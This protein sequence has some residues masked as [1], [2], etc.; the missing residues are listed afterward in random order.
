MPLAGSNLSFLD[1][2][3]LHRERSIR[4]LDVTTL[5]HGDSFK[6]TDIVPSIT[7]RVPHD[8]DIVCL[9]D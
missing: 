7:L 9:I 1:M 3:A 4:C 6:S 5:T 2:P 8:A